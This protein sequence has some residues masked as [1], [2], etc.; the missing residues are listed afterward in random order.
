MFEAKISPVEPKWVLPLFGPCDKHLR[1]ICDTL[2]VEVTH[3]DGEIRVTGEETAVALAT[4]VLE[5]LKSLVQRQ[6]E[7]EADEVSNILSR[8]TGDESYA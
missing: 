3:H 2:D 5:Q 7:V 8:V 4:D 1:T 6:G